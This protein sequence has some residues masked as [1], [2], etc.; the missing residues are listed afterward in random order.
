MTWLA[1]SYKFWSWE[2]N[3]D[4]SECQAAP[5]PHTAP[6]PPPPAPSICE[7]GWMCQYKNFLFRTSAHGL[8]K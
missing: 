6:P 1:H 7:K 4:L 2:R 5:T 3:L 8:Q